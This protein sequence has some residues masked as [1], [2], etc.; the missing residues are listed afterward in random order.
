MVIIEDKT[1]EGFYISGKLKFSTNEIIPYSIYG[2][3]VSVHK[4]LN[5]IC[6]DKIDLFC[7]EAEIIIKPELKIKLGGKK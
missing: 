6:F 3:A 4:C 2:A 7:D 1:E 5:N